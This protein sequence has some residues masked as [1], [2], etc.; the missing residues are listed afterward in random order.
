MRFRSLLFA[1]LI[2]LLSVSCGR[3]GYTIEGNIIDLDEGDISLLDAYGH[4]IETAVVDDG[5]FT[6]KGRVDTPCLAYINN[7]RGVTYPIDI[8][9]LLE[10]KKVITVTGDARISHIDIKGTK[11]NEDMVE[12]K[13]RKDALAADDTEGY[14]NLVKEMFERNSDN[15]LGSL[16]ISNFYSFVSDRELVGYCDRLSP[17]FQDDPVVTHYRTLSQARIDTEPGKPFKE[18]VL[19]GRDS[20]EVKLSDVVK[21]NKATVL[22]FWASWSREASSLIPEVTALCRKYE[23]QGLTMFNVSLDSDMSRM[24]ACEKEFGLFGKIISCGPEAGDKAA[25]TYGFEGL[26]RLVLID[27]EGKIVA[28]GKKAGDMSEGLERLFD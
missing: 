8:P 3:G 12:F 17:E 2:S 13:I 22:L 4:T 23:K 21:A 19:T 5:K 14:L 11:A 16:L 26:P 7:A 6:F 27:S 9:V 1:S 15:V 18:L 28:K 25:G 20:L 24:E 10:N